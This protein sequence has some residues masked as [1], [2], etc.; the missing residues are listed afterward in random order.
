VKLLAPSIPS[1]LT[2]VAFVF[3]LAAA[4]LGLIGVVMLALPGAV[5]MALG[6]AAA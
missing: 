3:F 2:V 1:G 4:Y 5:S 6:S